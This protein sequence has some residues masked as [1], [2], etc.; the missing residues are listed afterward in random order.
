M[1]LFVPASA[2]G[3]WLVPVL[4][5]ATAA[6]IDAPASQAARPAAASDPAPPAA[7]A[8][9]SDAA[10]RHARRA[11]CLKEARAKKLVGADRNAFV[12]ACSASH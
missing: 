1:R 7:D 10:A 3:L 8:G 4:M 6:D 2:M 5:G 9:S 11:A 12:K